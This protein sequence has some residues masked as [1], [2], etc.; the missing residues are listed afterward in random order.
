MERATEAPIDAMEPVL[1]TARPVPAASR[2]FHLVAVGGTAM[3]PLAALLLARGERV[4][5]SDGPLYPP[6]SDRLAA[7]GVAVLPAY[8]AENVGA[9]VTEVVAGNL[10]RKDNPEVLEALRRGLRVRSMPEALHDEILAGRHSVVVAGTHGK[11]TTTALAAWLLAAAGRDPG[12][13][14]GGEPANFPGPAALGGGAPFV[15]E[16]DEYSTSYADKGPKFLHYAPQTFV[17]TSVEFDHADLYPDLAAVKAAFRAGAAL[18]PEGGTIV[19]N[20][21]DANV[22]EV[23]GGARAHVLLYG[24][25]PRPA[26]APDVDLLA[27]EV[28][29]GE[30][31][32]RFTVHRSGK[33]PYSV[34]S[35]LA[36]RH[37][38]SNVL[39]AFGVALG[40][41]LNPAQLAGGLASFRGVKR[42][43][44][45]VGTEGGVTVVDDFAHHPTAVATTV[46]G[47]KRRFPGRRVWAAFE[48]RSMT[49][50]RADF[51]DAWA[52]ALAGA[53][54]VAL[55][56]PFHAARLSR[57]GGPGALD[58]RALVARLEAAGIPALT[59]DTPEALLLA[60][61]PALRDGDVVLSMSSGSFGGFPR[62]L[63]A[64]LGPKAPSAGPR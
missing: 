14:V 39:A 49:A 58:A 52:D 1:Q 56:A 23:L 47:A 64:A 32:T 6:M 21:D 19:A 53:G 51:F 5:G 18:V 31:G 8:S 10:A 55:A 2:T 36:G 45:I 28:A 43:M 46:A 54:G 60:L 11:T 3:T 48:P 50:G 7:L 15:V 9:D 29:E 38:V 57:P 25:A 27:T 61:V 12:Y 35:P 16:G 13:L 63:L 17:L 59:A 62:K 44:E 37:N 42:R 24:V 30:G 40:F 34:L 33:E 41:G 22:R 4:T 26:G 20:G